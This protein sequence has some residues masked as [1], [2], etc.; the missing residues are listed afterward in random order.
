MVG[1]CRV[2]TLY[3]INYATL[4][5]SLFE[6]LDNIRDI[7]KISEVEDSGSSVT[8]IPRNPRSAQLYEVQTKSSKPVDVFMSRNSTNSTQLVNLFE[9]LSSSSSSLRHSLSSNL[10]LEKKRIDRQVLDNSPK[11]EKVIV[12]G[13]SVTVTVRKK[14]LPFKQ[15]K[16]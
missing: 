16:N 5:I 10:T 15:T 13:M 2:L 6:K 3:V 4:I 7:T 8:I 9:N 11:T 12:D 14:V 1:F